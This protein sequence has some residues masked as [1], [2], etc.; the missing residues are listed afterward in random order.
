MN[1][2]KEELETI[3]SFCKKYHLYLYLDGARLGS[4]L[5]A[6]SNTLQLSDYAQLTDAFYI[7]GTKN[8]ALLGEALVISN[9]DLQSNFR[10][11]MKQK[12]ALLA[13]GRLIG[14]Q[15][16]E[17]FKNKLY[18][19][20]GTQANEM[21]TLLKQGLI[22]LNFSFLVDSDTNQ[23]FPI[24]PNT[25]IEYL[26]KRFSFLVWKKY[27]DSD[28]VV[29]LVTSFSTTRQDICELLSA[30]IQFKEKDALHY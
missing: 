19:E 27:S 9:P 21:A 3:S 17:L 4:A 5:T 7:G 12:G 30:I 18:F 10:F 22:A 28:S 15:F 24:F 26:Q 23:L 14:I 25:L 20:I 13:K 1:I 29:R 2:A 8:G 11:S 6:S 16:L